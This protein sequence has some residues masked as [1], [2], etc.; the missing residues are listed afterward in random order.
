MTEPVKVTLKRSNKLNITN[1]H[2]VALTGLFFFLIASSVTASACSPNFPEPQPISAFNSQT[3]EQRF[4]EFNTDVHRTMVDDAGYILVGRF[5]KA[6]LSDTIYFKTSEAIKTPSQLNTQKAITPSFAGIEPNTISLRRKLRRGAS[7]KWDTSWF[8]MMKFSPNIE[9]IYFPGDC[10]MWLE[11]EKT[12]EY[13]I[14]MTDDLTIT[15]MIRLESAGPFLEFTRNLAAED[16]SVLGGTFSFSEIINRNEQILL[17]ET[18]SCAP[19][20][21]FKILEKINS[22]IRESYI[23]ADPIKIFPDD[24]FN[25]YSGLTASEISTAQ[26][27]GL[28]T[29]QYTNAPS[30]DKCRV[31][32]RYLSIGKLFYVDGQPTTG[33]LIPEVASAFDLTDTFY[34]HGFAP[35]SISREDLTLMLKTGT[36]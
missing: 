9:G 13:L 1:R 7:E 5:S 14:F 22:D 24:V 21:K 4:S 3:Y 15:S 2:W 31:G 16:T 27:R 28:R 20:P 34:Q 11:I 26:A 18:L 8:W 12:S 10:N 30:L 17:I 33:Q 35:D 19:T 23:Y 6:A 32:Q 36:E 29:G 25:T